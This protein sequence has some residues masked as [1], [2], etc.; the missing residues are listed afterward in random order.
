MSL[1]GHN[2]DGASNRGFAAPMA[3]RYIEEFGL[4]GLHLKKSR[5]YDPMSGALAKATDRFERQVAQADHFVVPN[6]APSDDSAVFLL[7]GTPR[8]EAGDMLIELTRSWRIEQ[9][10]V[11]Q[12][13]DSDAIYAVLCV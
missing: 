11:M 6:F 9:V 1:W 7:R 5:K 4:T 10:E 8:P 2:G 3:A 13:G 12:S